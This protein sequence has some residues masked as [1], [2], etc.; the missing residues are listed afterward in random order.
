MHEMSPCLVTV[1][2]YFSV[3]PGDTVITGVKIHG[4]DNNPGDE[5]SAEICVGMPI[6]IIDSVIAFIV[7][8]KNRYLKLFLHTNLINIYNLKIYVLLFSYFQN[9]CTAS[10]PPIYKPNLLNSKIRREQH[11]RF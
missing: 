7:I 4:D 1:R 6:V 11:I 5:T 2:K 3:A 8:V 10:I 9:F